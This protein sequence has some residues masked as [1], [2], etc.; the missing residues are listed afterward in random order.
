MQLNDLVAKT[1]NWMKNSKNGVVLSSRIR[2]A[3]NLENFPF[4]HRAGEKQLLEIA[5]KIRPFLKGNLALKNAL[6][7][8]MDKIGSLDRDFLI[9]RHLIS[10]QYKTGSGRFLVIGEGETVSIMVNEEDHLRIQVL[11]SGLQLRDC[12][13]L[14][15]KLDDELNESI[16]F[17]FSEDFGYLT[18]CP[19]NVGTGMRASVMVHLPALSITREIHKV[20]P[21]LTKLGIV[22][23]GVYGEGSESKGNIFQVSNGATLGK[24]EEEIVNQM[25]S[26]VKQLINYEKKAQKNLIFRQK[27][28]F[29]NDI[30][31]AYGI[32]HNS[33]L[34][35]SQ[36]STSLLSTLRLG[37]DLNIIN[38][39]RETINELSILTLPAHIQKIIGKSLSPQ[40]RDRARAKLIRDRLKEN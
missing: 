4:P 40:E 11:E 5:G 34:L 31:R 22:E 39:K 8:E 24:Q 37:T 13:L 35:S 9:E 14:M 19:T 3:R 21:A 33:R 10:P 23:R 25:E 12:W 18:A 7:V 36:E 15:N 29:E 32:L 30:W 16:G 2:L 6:V 20:L 28:A 17:A 1:A 38:L 27:D 26:L